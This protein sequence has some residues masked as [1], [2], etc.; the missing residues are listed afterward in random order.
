MLN[1]SAKLFSLRFSSILSFVALIVSLFSLAYSIRLSEKGPLSAKPDIFVSTADR[2]VIINRYSGMFFNV[3]LELFNIG[4]AVGR[5]AAIDGTLKRIG[6][7]DIKS[8]QVCSFRVSGQNDIGFPNSININPSESWRGDM[9]LC[10]VEGESE[11]NERAELAF[12]IGKEVNDQYILARDNLVAYSISDELLK[13]VTEILNKNSKDIKEGEYELVIS[14][15]EDP[16]KQNLIRR[17]KYTF[18]LSGEMIR[19]LKEYQAKTYKIP[20]GLVNNR[21][22]DFYVV[23]ALNRSEVNK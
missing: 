15:W 12:R 6:T 19:A 22:I 9:Y 21:H 18:R 23:A 4:K 7:L 5:I 11:I 3:S 16:V 1:F 14:F 8:L 17:N 10:F 20:D 2:I 13:D